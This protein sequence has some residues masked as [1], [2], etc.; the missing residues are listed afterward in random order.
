MM[1]FAEFYAWAF[2]GLVALITL[3]IVA[4]ELF[5]PKADKEDWKP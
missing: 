1:T 5:P 2:V 3:Y 4:L